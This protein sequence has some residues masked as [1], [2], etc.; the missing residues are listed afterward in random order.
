MSSTTR[1]LR[2]AASAIVLTLAGSA[3]AHAGPAEI[4]QC[5]TLAA[6]PLDRDKPKEIEGAFD[7]EKKDA[8]A[9]IKACTAAAD[10]DAPR[11][12]YFQLG[13][14]YE[15]NDAFADAGKN[16]QKAADAGSSAAMVAMAMLNTTGQGMKENP[17]VA[18]EWFEK[19]ANAGDTTGMTNFGSMLAAGAG[20]PKDVAKAREWLL[21]AAGA[22]NPD[23]MFQLGMMAQDGEGSPKDDKAA[24]EWFTKAAAVEHPGAL[25]VLGDYARDGRAG[26]K[27][28]K[29]A[30]EFYKKAAE[31]G[32][33]EAEEAL[34]K[35]PK[36]PAGKK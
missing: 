28:L 29:A 8:M 5:D 34:K 7:M 4:K 26:P 22:N 24:K 31:M 6:H 16:Y 13:R 32:D 18:R 10:K 9:A 1:S 12:I 15:F 36:A 2:S 3:L 21:K 14:A 30:A 35:L 23:A 19:A 25:F 11:R 33:E 17:Q 20:G 27:D